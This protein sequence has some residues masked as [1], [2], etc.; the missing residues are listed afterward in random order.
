MNRF[1]NL[2]KI[3]KPRRTGAIFF[4]E[5]KFSRI[6]LRFEKRRRNMRIQK[7]YTGEIHDF[8]V[9]TI[10]FFC[11]RS[12]GRIYRVFLQ[13][14]LWSLCALIPSSKPGVNFLNLDKKKKGNVMNF[15]SFLIVERDW[16]GLKTAR[17]HS[18]FPV[19]HPFISNLINLYPPLMISL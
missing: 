12:F 14:D 9:Y 1:I 3:R 11:S 2:T 4:A 6:L 5:Y 10:V 13:D 19:I 15:P 8:L 17:F 16:S 7:L 18:F